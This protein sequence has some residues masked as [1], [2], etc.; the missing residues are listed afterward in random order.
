MLTIR[1]AGSGAF[2][3]GQLL[4]LRGLGSLIPLLAVWAGAILWWRMGR[5]EK[6]RESS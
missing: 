2:N 6:R 4:G 5:G 1:E 3:L